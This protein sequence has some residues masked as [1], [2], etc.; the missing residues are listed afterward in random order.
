[1]K[2]NPTKRTQSKTNLK[3][4]A[5]QLVILNGFA[6]N[7]FPWNLG[8]ARHLFPC[9]SASTLRISEARIEACDALTNRAL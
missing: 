7:I 8:A 5:D 2:F 1:M 6:P 9:H 3:L 4:P